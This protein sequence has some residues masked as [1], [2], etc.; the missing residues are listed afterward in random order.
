MANTDSIS[1]MKDMHKKIIKDDYR[2]PDG[3][4]FSCLNIA[5][6]LDYILK[7]EGKEPVIKYFTRPQTPEKVDLIPSMFGGRV[8]WCVH[9]VVGCDGKIFDPLLEIPTSEDQYSKM[10]FGEDIPSEIYLT[11]GDIVNKK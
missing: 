3:K 7:N 10:L 11:Y 5:E 8:H 9:L 1:Y 4:N 6:E 2:K